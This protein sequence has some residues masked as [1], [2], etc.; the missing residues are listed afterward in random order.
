MRE[1][2]ATYWGCCVG[3]ELGELLD[4]EDL[5]EEELLM[6]TRSL[7]VRSF[8]QNSISSSRSKDRLASNCVRK[9]LTDAVSFISLTLLTPRYWR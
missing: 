9:E 1:K 3:E 4:K 5:S 8:G 7:S 2:D 6:E